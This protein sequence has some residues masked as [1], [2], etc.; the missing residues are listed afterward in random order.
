MI[1]EYPQSAQ[2]IVEETLANDVHEKKAKHWILSADF[3]SY[4]GISRFVLGLYNHIDVL[5]SP[6]FKEYLKGEILK[7]QEKAGVF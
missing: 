2:F 3:A 5:E 6:A 7:M 4:V 1:E